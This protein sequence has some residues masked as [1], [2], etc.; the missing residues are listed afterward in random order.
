MDNLKINLTLT[1]N[2]PTI[3]IAMNVIESHQF[4]PN[5]N[6]YIQLTNQ[7]RHFGKEVQ[8]WRVLDG[9][10]KDTVDEWWKRMDK[11]DFGYYSPLQNNKRAIIQ[12]PLNT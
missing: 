7:N 9:M 8:E 3:P 10:L 11:V 5:I 6:T 4:I 12:A 2:T 1:Q